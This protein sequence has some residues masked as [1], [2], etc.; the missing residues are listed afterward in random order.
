MTRIKLKTANKREIIT[1]GKSMARDL[2]NSPSAP[3]VYSLNEPVI[4]LI[5]EQYNAEADSAQTMAVN[6]P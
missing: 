1:M 3:S 4:A 5:R 2:L 6:N